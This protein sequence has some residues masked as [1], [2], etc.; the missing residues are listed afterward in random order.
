MKYEEMTVAK[1]LKADS[2]TAISKKIV[3]VAVSKI[4]DLEVLLEIAADILVE[5]ET[6]NN[7]KY[8]VTIKRTDLNEAK[9]PVV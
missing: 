3:E 6:K 4:I 9:E 7:I 5:L 1:K 8:V 2:F